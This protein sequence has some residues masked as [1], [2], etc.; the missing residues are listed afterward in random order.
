MPRGESTDDTGRGAPGMWSAARG[1][2]E[3]GADQGSA[4]GV[5]EWIRGCLRGVGA[6]GSAPLRGARRRS[7]GAYPRCLAPPARIRSWRLSC[8]HRVDPRGLAPGLE[9]RRAMR[10]DADPVARRPPHRRR[11]GARRRRLG[12]R[13]L[14]PHPRP[15]ALR[16]GNVGGLLP[17]PSRRFTMPRALEDRPYFAPG[18]RA[19]SPREDKKAMIFHSSSSVRRPFHA[20]MAVPGRPVTSVAQTYTRSR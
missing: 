3:R 6:G 17:V 8:R 5:R 20:G 13:R 12:R 19:W 7:W 1:V 10:F 11:R 18:A 4:G 9:L 2:G 14:R 16:A 15:S